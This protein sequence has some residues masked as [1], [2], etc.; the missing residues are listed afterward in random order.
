[1]VSETKVLMSNE[2]S[3]RMMQANSVTQRLFSL[4]DTVANSSKMNANHDICDNQKKKLSFELANAQ[5]QIQFLT[6]QWS[7]HNCWND[8]NQP[9]NAEEFSRYTVLKVT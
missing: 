9:K 3:T 7:E 5:Q 4:I 2:E 6:Q 8:Q 1:M